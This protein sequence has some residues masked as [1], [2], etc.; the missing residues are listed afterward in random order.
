MNSTTAGETWQVTACATAGTPGS[1]PCAANGSTIIG[2]TEGLMMVP[3]NLSAADP[4]LDFS[5]N[6]GN[7][8]VSQIA[9]TAPSVP[10]PSSLGLLLVGMLAL[11]AALT[12][13]RRMAE[14]A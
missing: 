5:S 14:Q 1:G 8:L 10:E 2:T 11:A 12:L 13:K 4:F 3:G 9:A 6:I 7:V